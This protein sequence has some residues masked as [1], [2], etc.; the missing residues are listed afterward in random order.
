[1]KA[2][3]IRAYFAPLMVLAY[4][5]SFMLVPV[6]NA[7]VIGTQTMLEENAHQVRVEHVQALLAQKAVQEQMIALGVDP[8][9]AQQ[10]VASLTDEQLMQ[11]QGNLEDLPAG[12]GALVIIG[13]V[14]LVLLILELVGVINVFKG[15]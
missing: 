14:F 10:R 3:R 4:L 13:A 1:M 9:D 5:C 2:L 11:V 15:I 8:A 12:G 6:A 7:S